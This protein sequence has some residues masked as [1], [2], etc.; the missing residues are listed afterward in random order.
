[1]MSEQRF[2]MEQRLS[3]AQRLERDRERLAALLPGGSEHRPIEV[4]SASVIEGHAAASMPCPHCRGEYRVL[5]HTRPTPGLRR[6]D[7]ECRRCSVP[8]ALWYRIVAPE[9]N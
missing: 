8:R 5:E 7:V 1:M 9:L 2:A 4:G 3:D 6:V